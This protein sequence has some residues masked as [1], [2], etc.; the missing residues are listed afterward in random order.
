MKRERT[1]QIADVIVAAG[2]ITKSILKISSN[3]DGTMSVVTESNHYVLYAV[4]SRIVLETMIDA[5]I[6]DAR[7]R[8]LTALLAY[9]AL[10][11]DTG[12]IRMALTGTRA[13]AAV[14]MIADVVID[15]DFTA[16]YVAALI[17][18]LD[19]KAQIW[20][21]IIANGADDGTDLHRN[22]HVVRV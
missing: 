20:R 8:V 9:N 15:Q 5:P 22:Q 4:G 2:P 17:E 11:Q 1:M 13:T 12:M 21:E 3:E 10:W 19:A 6:S 14:T 16:E 18:D 7:E